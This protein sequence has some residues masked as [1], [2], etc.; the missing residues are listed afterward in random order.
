MDLSVQVMVYEVLEVHIEKINREN[1]A[2]S[3]VHA[4]AANNHN[5][6]KSIGN[7]GTPHAT[8]LYNTRNGKNKQTNLQKT[9]MENSIA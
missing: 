8:N 6:K 7:G 3:K 2:A 9:N 5:A 4:E 1:T